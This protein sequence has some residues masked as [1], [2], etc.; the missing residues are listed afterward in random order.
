[1]SLPRSVFLRLCYPFV[2]LDCWLLEPKVREVKRHSL[3]GRRGEVASSDRSQSVVLGDAGS[4][5]RAGRDFD[6][7]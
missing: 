4:A 5:L 1:M 7:K 6:V 3:S 2:G